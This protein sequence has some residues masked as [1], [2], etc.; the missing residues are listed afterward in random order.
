MKYRHAVLLI[1]LIILIDQASKFYIKLNFHYGEEVMVIGD[2]FRLHFLENEGMAFG[3]KLG[4][5]AIGKLVL[6]LFRLVAVVFGFYLLK[7]LVKRGYGKGV[8]ICGSLI[9]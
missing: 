2:W 3:M 6:T 4:D 5:A 7:R 9:R 8:I 1:V